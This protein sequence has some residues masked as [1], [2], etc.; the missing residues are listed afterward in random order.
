MIPVSRFERPG[1]TPEERADDILVR[2]IVLTPATDRA[3]LRD[4]IVRAIKAHG[5]DRARAVWEIVDGR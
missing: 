2:F 1:L 5:N 4:F 3:E